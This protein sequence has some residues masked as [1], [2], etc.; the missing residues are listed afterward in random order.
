[1]AREDFDQLPL[2]AAVLMCTF[3]P[4][5]D[6]LEPLHNNS[7]PQ[8]SC[9]QDSERETNELS[10]QDKFLVEILEESVNAKHSRIERS[11]FL[12]QGVVSSCY[13]FINILNYF[14][15]WSHFT[16]DLFFTLPFL[17]FSV[18]RLF[19]MFFSFHL[20]IQSAS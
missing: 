19:D 9:W 20:C 10:E 18:A 14:K 11:L 15:N 12:A 8:P 2:F 4:G 7:I 1:M 16:S 5:I 6:F 13:S 17:C 3:R